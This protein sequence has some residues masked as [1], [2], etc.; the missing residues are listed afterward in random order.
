MLDETAAS[1]PNER[2][3]YNENL[4][5]FAERNT[6]T[7]RN[8]RPDQVAPIPG[9]LI[10]ASAPQTAAASAHGPEQ[11]QQLLAV[12]VALGLFREHVVDRV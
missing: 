6:L 2:A 4:G 10:G 12:D 11:R 5:P 8:K 3:R 1:I 9:H 7:E